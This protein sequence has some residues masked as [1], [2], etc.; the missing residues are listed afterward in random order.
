MGKTGISL[1]IS[2]SII[3]SFVFPLVWQIE[4]QS[5]QLINR[6]PIAK[7]TF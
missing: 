3:L 4:I 2:H 5:R 6:I 7:I 1:Q